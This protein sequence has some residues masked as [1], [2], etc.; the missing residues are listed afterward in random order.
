MKGMDVVATRVQSF[1][2]DEKTARYA[3]SLDCELTGFWEPTYAFAAK[4]P[5]VLIFIFCRPD[6]A[7]VV[8]DTS[9]GKIISS[10]TFEELVPEFLDYRDR[11]TST[12]QWCLRPFT[13]QGK[14]YIPGGILEGEDAKRGPSFVLDL[15][16]YQITRDKE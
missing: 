2:Y 4:N 12:L 5:K 16:S 11:S 3:L 6:Q 9:S 7:L 1:T 13:G 10:K 8:V 15:A 14:L